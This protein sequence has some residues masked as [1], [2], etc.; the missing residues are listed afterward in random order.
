MTDDTTIDSE[1][2]FDNAALVQRSANQVACDMGS[3]VVVLDLTSGM[4]YGLDDLGA[5][6]WSL[7]EHPASLGAIRDAITA[8]YDVDATTC[9]RDILAFVQQMKSVGLVEIRNGSS[10]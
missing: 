4:Y 6:I 7:I 5:R 9:E 10:A 8:D 3:E 1:R 2:G